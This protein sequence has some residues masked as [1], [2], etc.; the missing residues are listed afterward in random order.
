MKDIGAVDLGREL[1]TGA[2]TANGAEGVLG[3]VFMLMGENS[4]TGAK[5][6]AARISPVTRSLPGGV[7][8]IALYYSKVSV[9]KTV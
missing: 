5:A 2:A 7:R 3:T 9:E 1:R 4:R 6:V 8:E